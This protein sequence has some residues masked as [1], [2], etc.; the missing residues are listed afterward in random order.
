MIFADYILLLL[1]VASIFLGA[2][3]GF[4]KGLKWFTKGRFGKIISIVVCYFLFGVV[5]NWGVVQVL[6]GKFTAALEANG[7]GFCNFL[8][9]I[10]IDLIVFAIALFI[11]VQILRIIVVA[12]IRKIMEIKNKFFIVVNKVLGVAL[13]AGFAAM[14]GLIV[15][16][17]IAWIS[18]AEGPLY[19]SLQGSA[20]GLDYVFKNNPLNA[21]FESIRNIVP[22]ESPSEGAFYSILT[23]L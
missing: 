17:I 14:A 3:F 9:A 20:F 5:L 18:G 7:S 23:V 11:I 10:R 4:G 2:I 1:I 15:F 13:F 6:L 19:Q 8:L 12:I 21:F 16:Q 22:S